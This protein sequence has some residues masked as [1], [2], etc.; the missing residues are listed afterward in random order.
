VLASPNLTNGTNFRLKLR[1]VASGVSNREQSS[2]FERIVR[3]DVACNAD[4]WNVQNMELLREEPILTL[5]IG[6]SFK[7]TAAQ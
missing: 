4:R 6:E 7:S 2:S 5:A 3:G 1:K